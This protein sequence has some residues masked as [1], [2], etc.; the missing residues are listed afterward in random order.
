MDKQKHYYYLAV[1]RPENL[2]QLV[3]DGLVYYAVKT[4]KTPIRAGDRIVLY[5]SRG[6]PLRGGGPGI[7]GTFEVTQTPQ[8][9]SRSVDRSTFSMLY[10]TQIPWRAITT[11]LPNPLA[12]AP[13]VPQLRMFPN[14]EKYGS[15][16]QTT[17]KSLVREDYELIER[18]LKEHTAEHEHSGRIAGS[19]LGEFVHHE[20]GRTSD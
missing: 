9:P 8:E 5:R 3:K 4:K 17:L 13:L 2:E 16:L 7:V 14:K 6:G 12:I 11:S 1:V 19:G 20:P 18:A 15:A 10:P